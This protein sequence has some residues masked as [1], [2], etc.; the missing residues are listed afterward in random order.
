MT[1]LRAYSFRCPCGT[2][3]QIYRFA[4]MGP[5]P[6]LCLKCREQEMPRPA[7]APSPQLGVGSRA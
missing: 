5:P 2:H 3:V 4:G 1:Q 6:A 7:V